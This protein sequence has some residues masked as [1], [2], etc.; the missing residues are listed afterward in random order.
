MKTTI[1]MASYILKYPIRTVRK[2]EKVL[3][4]TLMVK[5]PKKALIKTTEKRAFGNTTTKPVD[6]P[7]KKLTTT[8]D[9]SKP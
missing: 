3:S 9:S 5:S 6:L 2:T 8:T 4:I 1:P 7:L